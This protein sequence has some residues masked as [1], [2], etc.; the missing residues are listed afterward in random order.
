MRLIRLKVY[1]ALDDSVIR[2]IKF[3]EQGLSLIV[4]ETN[5]KTSGSNIGKTTA[6]KVIDLCLGANA[7]SSIYKEGDTGENHIIREFIEKNKGTEKLSYNPYDFKLQ[8]SNGQQESM[9]F[10]TIDNDTALSSGE[11]ISGGKVSGTITFETIKG[12]RGLSLIYNNTI[13][14]SKEMKI[15]LK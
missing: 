1:S 9:T 7:V 12:D 2:L 13:W 14:D 6:V 15:N 11:L 10:A 3:N 8:N 4:D 5:S